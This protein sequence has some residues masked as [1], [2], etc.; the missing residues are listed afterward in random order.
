MQVVL[1]LAQGGS[2][3]LARDLAIGLDAG[4]WKATICA[5]D[6]GGPLLTDLERA[7][8]PVHIT[9]RRPGFDWRLI[10]RLSNVF[11]REGVDLVQTHHLA[12]L[13]YGA[14]AARIA[15][16]TL[17]HVE[18]DRFS[19]APT[20]ARRRLRL[21]S[22]LCHRIVVVGDDIRDFLVAEGGLPAE[23]ITVIHNGVAVQRYSAV[24]SYSR[25]SL[26]LPE[27]GR[28][29]GHVARLDPAKDQLT[30]L[31]AFGRVLT[32]HR[33]TH[34]VIVGDG[35]SRPDLMGAA[36][37]LGIA[38]RV[39]WLGRRPDVR[40]LLPH[41]DVFALSSVNEGL[42]LALLEAMACARP[43]VATAIGDIPRVVEHGATGLLVPATDA[44]ALAE[45]II[46]LL[47][48]PE[49]AQALG[50]AARLVVEARFSLSETVRRYESLYGALGLR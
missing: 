49:H 11:R 34:L 8:I 13:I 35:T 14:V 20:Q 10:F 15:G 50:E 36:T 37:A 2:E 4:R 40:H 5:L 26:E 46:G 3:T 7:N 27:T 16:A 44:K 39:I 43:V 17:V 18:H 24:P 38:E 22:R 41:F 45:A 31:R 19:F 33:D 12:P 48:R 1:S 28:L 9:G 32:V 21:L 6:E 25:S 23:K 42:P 30:L 47:D 29:V